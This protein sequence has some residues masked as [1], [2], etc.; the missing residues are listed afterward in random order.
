[1]T[2][3]PTNIGASVRARLL[4]KAKERGDDFNLVLLRY[5]NERLLYRLALSP[6]A[7]RF[8]LKGAALF[9]VWTGQ[10]HRASRDLDLLGFGDPAQGSLRA[11]F[12]EVLA[13]PA[14]DDGVRFDA[15]SLVAGPIREDD[16][17][18]GVRLSL[19][20]Y[21]DTAKV[22]LQVD[23]GSETRSRPPIRRWSSFRPCSTFHRRASARIRARPSLAR[24]SRR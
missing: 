12:A 9:M 15:G 16:Q 4:A 19:V 21:I 14:D 24:N 3:K 10:P 18:G 11:L 22:T 5:A 1:M 13:F 23:V 6:H 17:Y 2:R 8:V 7:S 20:A